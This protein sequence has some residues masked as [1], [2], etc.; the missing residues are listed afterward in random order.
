MKLRLALKVS[1][2]LWLS[3][4]PTIYRLS[5][6]RRA[7]RRWQ[8]YSYLCARHTNWLAIAPGRN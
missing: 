3:D 1:A 8:K 6:V 5:T 7:V 2:R 4:E